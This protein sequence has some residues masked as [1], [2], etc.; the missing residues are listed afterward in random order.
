VAGSGKA[1]IDVTLQQI[2]VAPFYYDLGL[3]LS[4]PT[5]PKIVLGGANTMTETG[6]LRIFSFTKIPATGECLSSL[7][8]TLESSYV[9]PNRLI[10]FAQGNG[11]LNFRLPVPG[12]NEI[13]PD[14]PTPAPTRLAA[15][16]KP[17]IAPFRNAFSAWRE[18]L[19]KVFRKD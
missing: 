7:S 16:D 11:A 1:D 14:A 2:G 19:R 18:F 8:L 4:C 5:M 12:S 17:K 13:I 15:R 9:Y 6:E 10:K 3:A